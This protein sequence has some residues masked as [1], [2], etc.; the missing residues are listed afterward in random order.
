M[1]AQ[2]QPATTP[3]WGSPQGIRAADLDQL[4]VVRITELFGGEPQPRQSA[5]GRVNLRGKANAVQAL[6]TCTGNGSYQ[7]RVPRGYEFALSMALA[8]AD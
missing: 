8:P 2:Q 3:N 5:E 4:L 7:I 6:I 1:S